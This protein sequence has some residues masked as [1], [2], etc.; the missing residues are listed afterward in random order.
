MKQNEQNI[1]PDNLKS[2]QEIITTIPTVVI[3]EIITAQNTT[4]SQTKYNIPFDHSGGLY[5]AINHVVTKHH[6]KNVKKNN[7]WIDFSS[8]PMSLVFIILTF[9]KK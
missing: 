5:G 9:Q 4:T 2:L 6:K 7:L 1:T 3:E 8:F